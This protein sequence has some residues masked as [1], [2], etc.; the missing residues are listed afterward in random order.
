MLQLCAAKRQN[1]LREYMNKSIKSVKL[2]IIDEIGYMPFG[3]E[4]SRLLFEV[5]AKR[6][7]QSSIIVTSNLP[8]GQWAS[9]LNNDNALTVALLDRLLHHSP[10]F[11]YKEKVID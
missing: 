8:F 4:E 3:S 6:Y 5:I 9:S 7:E 10:L 1:R 11:N 2:L